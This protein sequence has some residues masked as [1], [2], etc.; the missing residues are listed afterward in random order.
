MA[1]SLDSLSRNLVGTNGMIC[2]KCGSQA[3]LTHIDENYVAHEICGKCRADSHRNLM[4]NTI[5]NNLRVGH[6]DEQFWL[7]LRKRVYPYK[8]IN[9]WEKFEENCLPPIE[10]FYSELNLSGISEC[11]YDH[12]Q[13]AWTVFGM[14]SLGDYHDLYLKMDV[15]LL[16]NVFENFR[17]TCLE[18]Y[19]LNPAH[20][21]TSPRLAWPACLKKI[22]VNLEL[23]TDPDMLLMFERGTRGSITQ[24]VHWYS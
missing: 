1:S 17:T 10:A 24:A 19:T 6:T 12:A 16:S 9:E 20:F 8:Y 15:L 2:N 5:F 21:Y 14:N 23:L 18:H 7:L 4:I 3:E 13:R 22:G 11:D